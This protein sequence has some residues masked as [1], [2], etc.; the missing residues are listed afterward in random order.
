MHVSAMRSFLAKVSWPLIF[1]QKITGNLAW[2]YI[3]RAK[4]LTSFSMLLLPLALLLLLL[5]V[6]LPPQAPLLFVRTETVLARR[7]LTCTLY[8]LQGTRH[9]ETCRDLGLDSFLGIFT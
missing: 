7:L 1:F 5:V 8:S 9:V 6:L 4:S 2:K 3:I